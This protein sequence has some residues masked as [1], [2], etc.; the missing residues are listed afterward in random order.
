VRSPPIEVDFI[1]IPDRV[2]TSDVKVRLSAG[3]TNRGSDVIDTELYRSILYIDGEPSTTWS[4]SIGNG[5]RYPM[6]MELPPGERVEVAREIPRLV[7]TPG[8]H[9]LILEVRGVRSEP[10]W[11]RIDSA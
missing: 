7:R 3:V 6:E 11:L 2:A 1:A 8:A 9:E 10:A 4:L 5:A